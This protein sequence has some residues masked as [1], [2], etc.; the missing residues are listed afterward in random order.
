MKHISMPKLNLNE[1]V[2]IIAAFLAY[3]GMYAV[4]KAFLAG[5]YEDLSLFNSFHFKTLLIISQVSGYMLS[6]FIG[7]KVVSE[8]STR[9][10]FLALIL[11]VGF[12][13][14]ML[15]FFALAPLPLKP[16][17]MFLNGLPLGM[18]FG[19]VL[20]YL[21]GRR[22]T[23][24]LVAGLSATFIFST[25]FVKS[26]G[27]WLMQLLDISELFMP[28]ATGLL[29][30]PVFVVAAY[31]LHR[32]KP[33]S[34]TDKAYRCERIPMNKRL[35]VGFL[36]KHGLIFSGL[37]LIYVLLTVVRDFRDNFIVEFWAELGYGAAPQLITLTEIPIAVIVLLL[38]ALGILI[39]DNRLA[40]KISVYATM[41]SAVCLFI[42]TYL[43]QQS[44]LS[45]IIWMIVSGACIYLP[46][47]LFHCMLF[48][49][50][51]ALLR[52]RAT[53]G[54]LFYVADA[55]GYLASVAVLLLK[56]LGSIQYAWIPFFIQLNMYGACSIL[57]LTI[58]AILIVESQHKKQYYFKESPI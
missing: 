46:Y 37:V 20:S 48:E 54:F 45:P 21:E 47:I 50:L 39:I 23:E 40:F 34:V 2:L 42:T 14:L 1:L 57:L 51:I 38:S 41:G 36:M 24:L 35:R 26:V 30:F 12:G 22:N 13:L 27:L 44:V 58:I 4:R 33:P 43:F 11:L 10:R 15:L 3:T 28:F 5:Q 9:H 31:M 17:A 8:L 55:L 25:G 18:V 7:I 6:K 53:V 32:S 56:E 19:F 49:R 16:L 29:F 52:Y